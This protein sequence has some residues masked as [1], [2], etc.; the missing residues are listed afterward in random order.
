MRI[1]KF[2]ADWCQPCKQ[3]TKTIESVKEQFIVPIEEVNIEQDIDTSVLYGIRSV[4]TLVL[5]DE[6]SQV[7]KTKVGAMNAQQF[8]DFVNNP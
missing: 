7:V 3:M 1:L 5:L 6:N 2:Y 8:L 4:P